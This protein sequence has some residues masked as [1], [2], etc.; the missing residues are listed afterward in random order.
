MART[1]LLYHPA[2]LDHD[3]GPGH[4][5]RPERLVAIMEE[6]EKKG[7]LQRCVHLTPV[8][9]SV[10][11]IVR[12][13][14]REHVEHIAQL[15]ELGWLVAERADTLVS[16]ATYRVA[17][18]AVGAV[19]QAAEAVMTGRADNA[20]CPIRPPGH[21]AEADQAMGFCYFNNNAIAA[22]YLQVHHGLE[23]V[24]IVDWDVH[25]S[26]G[27]QH[28][29]E[30]DPSVF[31]FSIHQFSPGFFPG[32][33]SRQERGRGRGLGTI[34]NAPQPPG[35]TDQDYLRVFQ[36]ELRPAIDRFQPQFILVSAGFDA[37]CADPL[38]GMQ[39]SE[40]GFAALTQEVVAMAADHCQGRLV[41]V[42]EGG[43]DLGALAASARAHVQV[44]LEA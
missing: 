19:L 25:H 18:L 39:L 14:T 5:E 7:L 17:R 42:L 16:P 26:N 43:Y 12:V 27:T 20:F 4:P 11:E 37:H 13:H 36:E 15:S 41:S 28:I 3:S 35:K 9:A 22:R 8:E 2:F 24:A 31:V 10:E 23:R 1:A 32:T 34:L 21:H 40:E 29:F 33:G 38:A 44:L 6:L 30:E